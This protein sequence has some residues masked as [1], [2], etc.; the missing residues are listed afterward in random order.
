MKKICLRMFIGCIILGCCLMATAYIVS[1]KGLIIQVYGQN[2]SLSE[3]SRNWLDASF[4]KSESEII[5]ESEIKESEKTDC[6]VDEIDFEK[7]HGVIVNAQ[8]AYFEIRESEDGQYHM[9]VQYTSYDSY[10]YY[11]DENDMFHLETTSD[12]ESVLNYVVDEVNL[13]NGQVANTITIPHSDL[14]TV[15]YEYDEQN[16]VYIRYAREEEQTD[17]DTEEP[18]TV[19]NIV[20]TKVENY[21]LNDGENKGRQTLSNIGTFDG[22][23]ITNGRVIPI[24]CTKDSRKEQTV[25][26]DLEGNEIEVNDGKTFIQICP[27]DAD[28]TFGTEQ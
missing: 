11:I 4:H 24:K 15:R 6:Y 28:V 17:W 3:I 12:E 23:Y 21:D 22:Y 5:S 1:G 25:Y 18:V 13:E 10:E 14:Q 16:Q 20:I 26:K 7:I 2:Y 27:I 8:G 9:K 19:K